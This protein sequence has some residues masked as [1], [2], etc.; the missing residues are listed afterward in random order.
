MPGRAASVGAVSGRIMSARR[1]SQTTMTARRPE[2]RTG[3]AYQT[4]DEAGLL[5][6]RAD[7]HYY[8]AVVHLNAVTASGRSTS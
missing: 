5:D 1:L 3:E 6:K 8:A 4:L 7:A 2:A